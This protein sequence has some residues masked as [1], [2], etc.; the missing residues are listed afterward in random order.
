M[1]KLLDRLRT[2]PKTIENDVTVII[3]GV[4]ERTEAACLA[5]VSRE[6]P[7]TNIHLIHETPF[8]AALKKSYKIGLAKGR[9]WTMVVDADV[10]IRPGAIL[11]LYTRAENDPQSV[12]VL[13]S[14]MLDNFFGGTRVGG[15]KL[16]RTK[17]LKKALKLAPDVNV[18]PEG[19]VN[20][21]MHK[22]G[23]YVDITGISCGLHDFEQFYAD[24]FRKGFAHGNK[25]A[26]LADLLIPYWKRMAKK[27]K[28][29]AVLLAGFETAKHKGGDLKLEKDEVLAEFTQFLTTSKTREKPA[30]KKKIDLKDVTAIM[31]TFVPP[32]EYTAVI[33]EINKWGKPEIPKDAK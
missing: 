33:R 11:D 29:F 26:S 13:I 32:K 21:T 6:I 5:L 17:L 10:L 28:D 25:H 1:T 14:D 9:K 22:N 27:D 23:Y 15:V 18:R 3:R 4:G 19:F 8:S 2:K 24:I 30:L 16:Y 31:D 7:R 20:K 12:F